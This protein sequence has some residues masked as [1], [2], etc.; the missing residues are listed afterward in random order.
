MKKAT[1]LLALL[2]ITNFGFSQNK[3]K[4]GQELLDVPMGEMTRNIKNPEKNPLID[5]IS[6]L[7]FEYLDLKANEIQNSFAKQDL[8]K[9]KTKEEVYKAYI[10]YLKKKITEVKPVM[11]KAKQEKK[12]KVERKINMQIKKQ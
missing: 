8:S 4:I 11:Q 10:A 3:D 6:E 7:E 9:M 5:Q 1:L 12:E 2:F